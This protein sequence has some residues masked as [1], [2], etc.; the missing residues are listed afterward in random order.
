MDQIFKSSKHFE[1]GATIAFCLW[2]LKNLGKKYLKQGTNI[3]KM[4]DKVTGYEDSNKEEYIKQ[5]TKLLMTIISKK[6]FLKLDF[7]ADQNTLEVLKRFSEP[8][9]QNGKRYRDS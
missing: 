8:R 1:A 4:I 9:R 5:A 6:K 7:S 2:E 3:E